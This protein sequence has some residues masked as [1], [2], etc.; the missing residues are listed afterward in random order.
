MEFFR[1]AQDVITDFEYFSPMIEVGGLTKF[2]M[3]HGFV[4]GV[5]RG[6]RSGFLSG[7][8]VLSIDIFMTLTYPPYRYRISSSLSM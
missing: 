2:N 3:A 4:E 8:L 5:V 1:L 6:M 7:M